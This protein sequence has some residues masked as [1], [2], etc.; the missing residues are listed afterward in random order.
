[1]KKLICL[2]VALIPLIAIAQD[3]DS[4]SE[5]RRETAY[6]VFGDYAQ[7]APALTSLI[8]IIAKKDKKGFWQFA[9]SY[10]TTLGVTYALKYAIN[11][12]RPDGRTDG[13]AF[14]SGHT[15]VA[16][17]GA[18]FL[19]RRYGWEYG[20]PAYAIAGLVAYTRLEGINQRH[21]G[22]DILGGALVGIGSTYLFATPYQ[23]EHYEL[24]FNS[25]DGNYLVGLKYK[26]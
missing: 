10:G 17:S 16:F 14:P 3:I 21:D 9:K 8:V 15:A 12:P 13:K 5:I 25:G 7:H 24:T 20:I 4:P 22:W 1:M 18:S 26:F 11:K 19:Q 2:L 23:K 6:E